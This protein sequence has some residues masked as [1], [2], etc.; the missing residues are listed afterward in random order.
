MSAP[1]VGRY[2]VNSSRLRIRRSGHAHEAAKPIL[3][4][5]KLLQGHV[6]EAVELA[7]HLLRPLA[8]RLAFGRK[9]NNDPPLVG[10]IASTRH[11]SLFF[12]PLEH[13]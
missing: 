13:R 11:Q 4:I 7:Q 2:L 6:Q 9:G 8:K 1:S 12:D 10:W 3:E 5:E